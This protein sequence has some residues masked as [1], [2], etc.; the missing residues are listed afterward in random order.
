ML[1]EK[2][3]RMASD[4]ESNSKICKFILNMLY[5]YGDFPNLNYYLI[6]L[7]RK[8]G[9]LK[10]TITA[11]IDLVKEWLPQVSDME[12]KLKLF[13]TLDS[14]TSGKIFLE[15][16]RAEITFALAKIKEGQGNISEAA[17]ILQEIE[18]ETFGSLTRLQK[19]EY[20]LEQ[21]R[22]HFLNEDYIRFFITSKKISEK[23]L[24]KDDFCQLKLKYY[25]FMIKYYLREK[26]YFLIA[27]AFKRRL[28]TL[29]AMEDP[30]WIQELECLILF[31]LISPMDDERKAFMEETEKEGKKLKEIP[32]LAGFLREFM[33]DNMI[34]WPPAPELAQYLENHVTFK[35]DPLPGGKERIEALRDRVIQHNVLIVSK[36][37]TRITLQRLA[38]LVNSTVDKLEEEV[39]IMVSRNALYAKINR[40]DGI[41]KFGKRKEPED[42]LDEWSKNIAGL[43]DLVDQCSRLVQKERMIHEARAK[44]IELENALS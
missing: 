8:R 37:Y 43:M 19:V 13:E 3:C 9:Q 27:E 33:S 7:S 12:T 23:T 22:I 2:R 29:F 38:E 10:A 4:G 11:M 16:Q 14:I 18:V 31:L 34:P 40:P 42:V 24:E 20:I 44:Q 39:S 41:I 21:M 1:A 32:L 6:L 35:D 30:Q 17:K 36:F 28:E 25:E 5:E 26:S 15:N